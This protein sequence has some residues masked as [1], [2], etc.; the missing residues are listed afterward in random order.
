MR[1]PNKYLACLCLCFA[2]AAQAQQPPIIPSI[3]SDHSGTVALLDCLQN[4]KDILSRILEYQ[5]LAAQILEIQTV[6]TG[7]VPQAPVEQNLDR[8]EPGMDRVNWFDQNLEIYAIVGNP[9]ALV[10]YA[11]L[12][13]REY[14][15]KKNDTIR[16]ARVI[17]VYQRGVTLKILDH[18]ISVE[19]SGRQRGH[20]A[21][22]ESQL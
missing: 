16:L 22:D 14:R 10:A 1:R 15:L 4:Q 18:E 5:Q 19:I 20:Q 9:N 13:G 3:C 6:G 2:S 8:P 12:D 17:D 11:R 21:N 7:T